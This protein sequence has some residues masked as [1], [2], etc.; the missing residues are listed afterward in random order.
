MIVQIGGYVLVLAAWTVIRTRAML[1]ERQKKEAA[2]YGALMVGCCLIG[3]LV[4]ARVNLPS[5]TAPARLLLE[6]LGKFLLKP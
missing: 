4:I 2:L 3:S 6:P 1:F 5:F